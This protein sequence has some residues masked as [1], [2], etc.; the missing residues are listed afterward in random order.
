MFR[1][2]FVLYVAQLRF[3][4]QAGARASHELPQISLASRGS[5]VK[6][7]KPAT[8]LVNCGT[9][10][11]RRLGGGGFAGYSIYGV[12]F[13]YVHFRGGEHF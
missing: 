12:I 8:A 10:E 3:Y 4:N 5:Y 2:V 7:L 9:L 13:R 6:G 1:H 11:V